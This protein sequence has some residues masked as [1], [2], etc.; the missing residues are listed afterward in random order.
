METFEPFYIK[1]YTKK[2]SQKASLRYGRRGGRTRPPNK[3]NPAEV[4]LI[5]EGGG[6]QGLLIGGRDYCV[7]FCSSGGY[8]AYLKQPRFIGFFVMDQH[9]YIYMTY[10][11]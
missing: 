4:F 3:K 1:T 11:I 10:D 7:C 9:I 8:V 2:F 6:G 5:G